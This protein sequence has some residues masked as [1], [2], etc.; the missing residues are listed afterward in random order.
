MTTLYIRHPAK[1]SL[2]AAAACAFVLAGDG[3]A[4]QQQGSAALGSLG[5][6]IA[7]AQ[8][9][10]LLLAAADVTLLRL[11]TP[12][13][14]GARLRAALPGLVEEHILGDAQDCVL[15]AGAPDAAGL[16]TIAVAQR[17]WIEVLVQA[18]LA[19]GARKV[20]VLP[21][22]LCL[23]LPPGGVSASLHTGSQ[24][25]ELALRQAP[26]EGLGLVLPLDAQQALATTRAFAGDV[27][28]TIYVAQEELAQY[29]QLAQDVAGVTVELDHWAHWIAASRTAGLDLAPA[30]GT[31]GTA[32]RNWSRWRW[33]LRLA[34]A[35]V[36]VNLA[37]INIEWSRLKREVATVNTS[38]QQTFKAAYPNEAPVFGLE[39]EQMR[40]NI[41]AA[42]LQGGQASID[43]FTGMSAAL[44]EAL[45]GLAGRGVVASLEYRER[46]LIVR[47]KPDMVDASA[48]AQVKQ[49]LAARKLDLNETEPG[50]WKITVATVVKGAAA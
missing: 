50:V 44:G 25:I 42:R 36:I 8:R 18:L 17:A 38:M 4:L 30:L 20:A 7:G 10:V 21:S 47:I 1:A 12:P 5:Q 14:A 48:Q 31:G 46:S 43:D 22:Q 34:L 41:A 40:R 39:E 35:A 16:R 3:G 49:G 6:L 37:G 15:A 11:K 27:P 24:G 19:Q 9:V 23:P 45:G 26:Q 2:D 33:P 29:Q 13:L 32:A 28:L